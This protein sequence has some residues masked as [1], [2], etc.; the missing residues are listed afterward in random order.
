[1]SKFLKNVKDVEALRAAIKQCK[2]NVILRSIDGSEEFNMKSVLSEYVAIGRL[3][4]EC[5]D[6]FEF[7]CMNPADEG[8]LMQYFIEHK[9]N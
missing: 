3:C 8:I 7:F 1:M 4:E 6:W 5:G 2:G 9:D